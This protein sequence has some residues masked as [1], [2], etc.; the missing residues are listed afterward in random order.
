MLYITK[1]KLQNL[2]KCTTYNIDKSKFHTNLKHHTTNNEYIVIISNNTNSQHKNLCHNLAGQNLSV[3]HFFLA[4]VTYYTINCFLHTRDLSFDWSNCYWVSI[5]VPSFQSTNIHI[6][7]KLIL[8]LHRKNVH[9]HAPSV[10]AK[11]L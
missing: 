2:Q 6:Y 7:R 5:L 4:W 9:V 1:M 3:K 10:P 11:Y 8:Q